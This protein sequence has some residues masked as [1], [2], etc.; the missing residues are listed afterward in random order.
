MTDDEVPKIIETISG[1]GES[2][3]SAVPATILSGKKHATLEMFVPFI[4]RNEA[5]E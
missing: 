4:Q 1:G 5:T 3:T 2:L